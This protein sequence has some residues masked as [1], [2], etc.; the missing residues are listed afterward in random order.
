[1][2][3][4]T[5][6]RT[7]IETSALGF[8]GASLGS[9]VGAEAG[10]RALAA[11]LDA[12]VG[13]I[14]L[15]PVYGGGRAE[16]IAGRVLRGRRDEAQICTKVGLRLA[17]GVGGG[18]RAAVMPLARRVMGR[19]GPLQGALRKAAPRANAKLPLTGALV[20]S[21]IEASLRRLG[22]DRVEVY[23]LHGPAPEELGDEG[24]RRAL[25]AVL[26]SGKA[27][28]ISVAGDAAAAAAALALGAP[29]GVIQLPLPA[30]G[31]P[32]A[33]RGSWITP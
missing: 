18:L 15:A 28:A 17:G 25:E 7:G 11:A 5:L 30:P 24:V 3:R 21:S 12:G 29:Y 8:G 19:L 23:A 13:W 6:G 4:V 20:T 27:R 32:D 1:M 33:G 26:A 16:E 22:T 9:R 31:A 2:R 14:D 10:A